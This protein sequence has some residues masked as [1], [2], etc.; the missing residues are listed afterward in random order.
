MPIDSL[1][2][3]V[4]E[5][6]V[7]SHSHLFFCCTFSRKVIDE[8]MSWFGWLVWLKSLADLQNMD[9]KPLK[10][11]VEELNVVTVAAVIYLIW[12][13]RN[14]CVFENICGSVG[15]ISDQVKKIVQIRAQ[16]YN[17]KL[18]AK[19]KIVMLSLNNL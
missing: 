3:P 1:L 6:D 8:I 17:S 2:C 10:G 19:E 9:P 15:S 18:N 12:C 5:L 4:C 16:L 7:E 14:R 11:L 13:N